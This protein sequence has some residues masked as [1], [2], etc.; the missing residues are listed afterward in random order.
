[1]PF[2]Y[3]LSA[4]TD[5]ERVRFH[6]GDTDEDTAIFQDQGINFILGEAGNWQQAV[7]S[8][9]RNIIAR[10]AGEPDMQADWLR[11]D[12]RRSAESW[13][14]LLHEKKQEFGLGARASSGGQHAW[15]PDSLQRGEPDWGA[16]DG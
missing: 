14:R 11:V 2:T 8:C 15:R 7:V 9:I 5:L 13:E 16:G 1:M 12:W 3:D 6:I 10:L 4:P